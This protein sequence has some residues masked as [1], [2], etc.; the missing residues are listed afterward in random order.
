ME[1]LKNT[2]LFSP[3]IN[4]GGITTSKDYEEWKAGQER[5]MAI[6]ARYATTTTH[7]KQNT[8]EETPV[9]APN[10]TLPSEEGLDQYLLFPDEPAAGAFRI[11]RAAR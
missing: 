6:R 4:Q 7:D 1:Q 3:D 2:I 5:L 11:I 10:I 9:I 8:T